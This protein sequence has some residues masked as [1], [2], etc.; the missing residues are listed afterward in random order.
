MNEIETRF[1][2]VEELRAAP[3]DEWPISGYGAVYNQL[4]DDLGGFVER[5]RPGAFAE[6]IAV[7]DIRSLFNHDRNFVLGRTAPG[8]LKLIDDAYGL[9]FLVKPPDTQWARD[10]AVSIK[11]GDITQCSFSFTTEE[12]FWQTENDQMTRDLVRV[13]LYDIGPVAFPAYPQTSVVARASALHARIKNGYPAQP[14][15]VR[16]LIASL[17]QLAP[18][19]TADSQAASAD[20]SE[21]RRAQA[22]LATLR[23]TIKILKIR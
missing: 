4:S 21:N 11:R 10:L 19:I 14:D 22:S 13:R 17:E 3:E 18:N 23:E 5:I 12:D 1:F 9:R 2:K 6:T 20:D 15:E 16:A 8:T 7:D